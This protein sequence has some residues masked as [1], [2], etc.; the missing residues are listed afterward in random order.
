MQSKPVSKAG[1][2]YL[3]MKN[4]ILSAELCHPVKS[5]DTKLYICKTCHKHL[6]KNVSHSSIKWL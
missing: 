2:D 4:I 3:S 6:N 5:F 1:S